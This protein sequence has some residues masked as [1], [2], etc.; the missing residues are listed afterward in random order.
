MISVNKQPSARKRI[1]EALIYQLK[2]IRKDSGFNYDILEIH[3]TT[4]SLDQLKRFPS[5]VIVTGDEKTQDYD[6]QSVTFKRIQKNMQVL[7]HAFLHT[8]GNQ[9]D[10]Q[11]DIIQDIERIIGEH[12]GLE[13]QDG[14]CTCFLAQVTNSRPW[15][16]KVN[17][18]SC[19][20][21]FTL[22]IRYQQLREDP[23]VKA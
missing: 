5:I 16:L 2:K 13:H 21:T 4:P 19:G 3:E 11:D 14:K 7:L 9:A 23:T 17:K 22:S 10:A 15:G 12:F 20:V 1:R 8:S 18:P 6:T